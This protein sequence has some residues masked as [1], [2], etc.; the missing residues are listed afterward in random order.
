[1]GEVGRKG[2]RVGTRL[3]L[4]LATLVAAA[5]L[6]GVWALIGGRQKP[7]IKLHGGQWES[8][9]VNNAI[10]ELI[11]EEGY[12]YPVETVEST[13]LVMQ[14]SMSKGEIDLNME[15]WQ[16]N[17]IDWYNEQIE[18]A[19]IVNLGMIFEAGPQVFIIPK[20][21]AEQH[22]IN[23]VS[24]VKSHWELFRDPEDPSKGVFYN[25]IIGWGC[26]EI[27]VV[28][29]E[30][31][32]LT[33]Y[34]NIVSPASPAALEGALARAQVDRQPVFGYYWAPSAIMGIYDWHILEEPP[35][36][37]ECWGRVMA[38]VEDENLR[39]S[40]QACA[41]EDLPVDKV[42]HS[43]LVGKAPDVVE[44]LRRMVVGLEPLNKTLAWAKENDVQ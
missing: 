40:D 10:A 1:M 20:W 41:Y 42:A 14:T 44:M 8:L 18:K 16:Q 9:W 32:G 33:R 12:G 39:P 2:Q 31:Y 27:N 29:L 43:G 28:K 3:S 34:Y 13:S 15:M 21:V 19:N 17:W 35:Y 25:G 4:L 26:T 11:I 37:D 22:G 30:A 5:L 36:T 7:L 23:S 6:I 38:A 24:D